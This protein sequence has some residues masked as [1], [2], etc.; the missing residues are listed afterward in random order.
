M[1]DYFGYSPRFNAAGF[2]NIG[3]GS[4]S[5]AYTQVFRDGVVEAVQGKFLSNF[6]GHT[7]IH[8]LTVGKRLTEVVPSYVGA[9]RSL[10]VNPPLFVL[11]AFTG[12]GNAFVACT[13]HP[14]PFFEPPPG[15]SRSTLS[16][17][18]CVFEDYGDNAFYSARLKPALDALWNAGGRSEWPG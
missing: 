5:R 2:I 14:G 18:I 11:I 9:L 7:C 6:A 13:E 8:A 1:G 3:A 15:L 4:P 10:D 12:V 17:P 16:L